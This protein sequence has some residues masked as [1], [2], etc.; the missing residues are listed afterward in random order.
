M[1][2]GTD[3]VLFCGVGLVSEGVEALTEWMKRRWLSVV[4]LI[5]SVIALVV[6]L[7]K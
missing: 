5:L 7:S 6:E 3:C 1:A 2:V 4:A